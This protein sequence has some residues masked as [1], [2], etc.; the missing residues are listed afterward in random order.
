MN[1]GSPNIP[2]H[3]KTKTNYGGGAW[4]LLHK[5]ETFIYRRFGNT[6]RQEPAVSRIHMGDNV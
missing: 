6:W 2:L 3:F 5:G 1:I 4:N